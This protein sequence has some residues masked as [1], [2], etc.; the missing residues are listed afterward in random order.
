M[1]VITSSAPKKE[2]TISEIRVGKIYKSN[3]TGAIYICNADRSLTQLSDYG[4]MC[5][6]V[7]Y[8]STA[9]PSTRFFEV[10]A[11]LHIKE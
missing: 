2:L 3:F 1:N 5:G 4:N 8:T 6:R 11:E 9:I 10:E 7:M